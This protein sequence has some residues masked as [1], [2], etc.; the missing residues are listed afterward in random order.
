MLALAVVCCVLAAAIP[1]A[2]KVVSDAHA[3]VTEAFLAHNKAV[4]VIGGHPA[5]VFKAQAL[6]SLEE[7]KALAAK[8][9]QP[10]RPRDPEELLS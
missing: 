3:R 6:Q 4:Q 5:D 7:R 2:L 10:A 8:R 9:Q 1:I